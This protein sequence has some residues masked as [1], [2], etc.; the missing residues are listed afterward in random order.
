MDLTFERLAE[1]VGDDF[2]LTTPREPIMLTLVGVRPNPEGQAGGAL[3]FTG[4][5][6][7]PISQGTYPIS[8]PD[9]G[10]GLLRIVPVG[11][12]TDVRHYEAV[13]R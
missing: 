12:T 11:G 4:P 9:I 13:F 10:E 7:R 6:E 2:D 8:H 1:C 3:D 5:I